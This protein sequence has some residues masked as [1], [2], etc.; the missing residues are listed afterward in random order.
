MTWFKSKKS[1]ITPAVPP[2]AATL[3]VSDHLM[4]GS[5]LFFGNGTSKEMILSRLVKSLPYLKP[6]DAFTAIMEKL[7]GGCF[8]RTEVCLRRAR[9]WRWSEKT[10][11]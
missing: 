10:F 11:Q 1:S 8:G 6:D 5:I 2:P 9:G 7:C 3:K 4:A